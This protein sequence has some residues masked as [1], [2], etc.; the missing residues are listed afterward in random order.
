MK[1]SYFQASI[2]KLLIFPL[3]Y[4]YCVFRYF[5][6]QHPK[7]K[8]PPLV[9]WLQG[10]PGSSS[11]IGLF[12]EMG[13][14]RLKLINTDIFVSRNLDTWNKKYGMLF[15]DNP[16]GSGFSFVNNHTN[17][18]LTVYDDSEELSGYRDGYV[19]N[20]AAVGRDLIH[21]LKEFYDYFPNESSN[22]LII[23]GES[24]A[25]KYIPAFAY[26]IHQ[27]NSGNIQLKIPL[28]GIAL[29][30][31]LTD[32]YS[33]ILVH[34]VHALSLGLISRKQ[35][36]EIDKL[37][38]LSRISI[39]QRKWKQATQYRVELFD[40]ISKY[41]GG[42]NLYDVR[43]L[44]EQGGKWK[45]LN[46][47]MNSPVIQKAIH[48]LPHPSNATKV[49]YQTS[50]K[51][52]VYEN[53]VE[54]I[55]KSQKWAVEKLLDWGYDVLVYQGQFDFRDGV[56]GSDEWI[57][58]LNWSGSGGYTNARRNVW[59]GDSGKTEG[60]VIEYRNLR[61]VVILRAGHLVPMD[62]PTASF[63]MLSSWIE[64]IEI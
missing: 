45:L 61:R 56:L 63:E 14:F 5:P 51:M 64:K 12:H 58:T 31:T 39:D 47:F 62:S 9:V 57:D 43:E 3:Q 30:N 32:P 46:L 4:G 53:L 15:L 6:A 10:G 18:P 8:N 59:I 50:K 48:V 28:K 41:S 13:P 17:D 7:S 20:E 49:H 22:Q 11:L 52:V 33:Q 16:V 1:S 55:M 37:A 54:D 23:A 25:G 21:A 60:F 38:N 26:A 2:T 24:Y 19:T 34:S 42:V 29:G 36:V 40:K 27:Y 35:A 44:T